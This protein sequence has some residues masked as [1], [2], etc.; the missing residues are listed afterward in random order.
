MSGGIEVPNT[1]TPTPKLALSPE[2]LKEQSRT[3]GWFFWTV[4]FRFPPQLDTPNMSRH[5]KNPKTKE[6]L[7]VHY[8]WMA[9]V[10]METFS[11]LQCLNNIIMSLIILH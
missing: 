1:R 4:P 7:L 8:S 6:S 11:W 9:D 3:T 10:R 5:F 2:R